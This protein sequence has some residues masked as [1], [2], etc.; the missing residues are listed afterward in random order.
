MIWEDQYIKFPFHNRFT[1]RDFKIAHFS[2]KQT[3][4]EIFK[5]Y[6]E[7]CITKINMETVTFLLQ[8]LVTRW[9]TVRVSLNSNTQ[10]IQFF[11]PQ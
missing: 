2:Q 11:L 5:L 6:V 4:K 10:F 8:D 3:F 1:P 7:F 9:V